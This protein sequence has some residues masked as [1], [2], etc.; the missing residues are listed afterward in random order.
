MRTVRLSRK[1]VAVPRQQRGFTFIEILISIGLIA[2]GILGFSLNTMGVI[3][4]NH[5]SGNY[6]VAANLAQDKLEQLK[7][8]ATFA[9]ADLCPDSGEQGLA[10][11]GV[12]GGIYNRCWIIKDSPL[13]DELKQIDV[14]VS[15][16]DYIPRAVTVST[17]VFTG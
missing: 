12:A 15:W 6:T 13:G 1:G 8:E 5:I 17:L 9:N 4:G 7:A 10:A 16:R 2:V 3:R 14:T 11:T